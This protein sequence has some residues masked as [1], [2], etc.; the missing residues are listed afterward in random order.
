[1]AY[2]VPVAKVDV[3]V[4]EELMNVMLEKTIDRMIAES[5]QDSQVNARFMKLQF[6]V[7]AVVVVV[8]VFVVVALVVVLVVVVMLVVVLV[9]VVLVVVLKG[10]ALVVSFFFHLCFS[11]FLGLSFRLFDFLSEPRLRRLRMFVVAR[12]KQWTQRRSQPC[13]R[14]KHERRLQHR[15]VYSTL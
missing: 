15:C 12:Q 1:M 7:A 13:W 2:I 11:F 10:V 3:I 8:V 4:V 6:V 9:L 5:R 14:P